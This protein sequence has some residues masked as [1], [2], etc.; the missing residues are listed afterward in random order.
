M[1]EI[2]IVVIVYI[3]SFFLL[4]YIFQQ[5]WNLSVPKITY[6]KLSKM[7]YKTALSFFALLV[8]FF[9][10]YHISYE[11]EKKYNSGGYEYNKFNFIRQ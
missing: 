6:D 9:I 11:I 8:L 7:D 5:L 2:V 10:P 4:A 1:S 3:A